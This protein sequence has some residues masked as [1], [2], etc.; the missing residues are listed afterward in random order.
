MVR[1]EKPQGGGQ[2][3][4]QSIVPQSNPQ[5][6]YRSEA[7]SS[8]ILDTT[9]VK[10]VTGRDSYGSPFLERLATASLGWSYTDRRQGQPAQLQRGSP[11]STMVVPLSTAEVVTGAWPE[12]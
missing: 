7:A 10:T 1:M 5:P 9:G 4:G 12:Q 8:G 6:P 11:L 2:P 3:G